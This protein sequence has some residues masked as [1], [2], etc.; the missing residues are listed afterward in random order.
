MSRDIIWAILTIVLK[1]SVR[2]F[3]LTLAR[4]N[5]YSELSWS[6]GAK[7][8]AKADRSGPIKRKANLSRTRLIRIICS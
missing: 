2:T 4:E 5:I 6:R 3:Y 1:W 8:R 7:Q